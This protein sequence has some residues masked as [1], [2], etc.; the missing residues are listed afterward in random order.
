MAQ[1]ARGG[2]REL[3]PVPPQTG[4]RVDVFLGPLP[5]L[6]AEAHE[7]TELPGELGRLLWLSGGLHP[8]GVHESRQYWLVEP[9]HGADHGTVDRGRQDGELGA[10]KEPGGALEMEFRMGHQWPRG[11]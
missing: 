6:L 7:F 8:R 1:G 4:A 10:F 9:E 11:P 3:R 2:R 5:E